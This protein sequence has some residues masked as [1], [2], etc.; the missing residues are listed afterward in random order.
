MASKPEA[1]QFIFVDYVLEP[2][3]KRAVF[4]YEIAFENQPSLTFSDA[5]VFPREISLDGIPAGLLGNALR[6]LHLMLG[7]SYYKLYCP[8]EI[9]LLTD[10]LSKEQADFWNA[11]YGRGLG[12]FYYRNGID[13]D[14]V[15]RFPYDESVFTHSHAFQRKDR[16]LVGIGGGKDSIVVGELLKEYGDDFSA[17]LIEILKESPISNAV[18]E[19]MDVS[20]VKIRYSL[21]PKIF[22]PH[23]GAYNGHIPIS[24]IFAFIGYLT[25]ILYDFSY[26]VV[27]NEQSSDFGNV[28]IGETE[29]NHQWSKSSEFERLFRGYADRFLSPDIIYFSLLRPFHE[30]R[31]AEMFTRF[32]KY[33]P[34][35]S[36]CNRNVRIHKERPKTIWCGECP[37][38]L[39]VFTM[40]SAF[41]EK[42][43]LVGIF[44]R[45]LYEEE[46]LIPSF[47]DI[48]GFGGMKPF[49][50][51]GTFEE[52]RA[53]LFLAREA[54]ADSIVMRTFLD[55]I[56]DPERLIDD[57]FRTSVSPMV[58]ARFALYGM[59][60]VLI[61]GYG[62]E[63]ELTERYLKRY[64]PGLEMAVADKSIDPDYLEKQSGYDFAIKTPGMR[65]DLVTIPYTTAT[66]IFFSQVRNTVVGVTGSKGKSTT[67]SLIYSILKEAGKK[68]RLLGNI[69]T[70]MVSVLLEPIEPDEI[71]VVE[72]SSYQ[73]DDI[74]HSPH[75]AVVLNLFPEHMDYHD[76][77]EKYYEAKRNI[78]RYQR[79]GDYF[80]YNAKDERLNVWGTVSGVERIAF[81]IVCGLPELATSLQGS[82]NAENI[83]AAITV[84]RLFDISEEPLRKAIATFVPLPHRLE[85]IG[86]Y[87]GIVFYDDAISTTPESTMM[88]LEAI[89]NVETLFLGGEDRG[90]DF[91]LLEKR[92]RSGS[93]KNVV[94]FPETG[95]RILASKDGFTVLETSSMEDAVAFAY[96]HTSSGSACLLS[97]ASPSYSL[98]KNFEEKGDQ[99]RHWVE[100]FAE[101]Q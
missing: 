77:V 27:G 52:S 23:E 98:W 58:P 45:D 66:N 40:L 99:F 15:I 81:P 57:V 11:I 91:S 50:C 3:N 67:A 44:G 39:F 62:K 73:L 80:I 60:N 71:F 5:V 9:V 6:S 76:G 64:F 97:T 8:P 13:P 43:T 47:A 100:T 83:S 2:E 37:K 19:L 10:P 78:V 33:F 18:A 82:H 25:A 32:P 38:C 49:D 53:A 79:P 70:P 61:L 26:V 30:I 12:E 89:P 59:K 14:I 86:E 65:K 7:I 55:R 35:F 94:L 29:V 92:M 1:T 51:V 36:S 48:L 41:L 34:V 28:R 75:I 90:Y 16:S 46:S 63:G 54:Y 87:R 24:A 93:I 72:L 20:S 21:D 84:A 85:R 22:E 74:K 56:E 69:G 42:N 88:A 95:K 17:L 96:K 68:V 101:E 4:R 31:I